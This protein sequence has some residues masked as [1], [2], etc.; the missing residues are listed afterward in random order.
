MKTMASAGG[1]TG[2]ASDAMILFFV[3][4]SACP[5]ILPTTMIALRAQYGAANPADI[6]LPVMVSTGISAAVGV[7]LCRLCARVREVEG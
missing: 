7:M 5:E 6:I 2:R 4:N 1:N 3:L